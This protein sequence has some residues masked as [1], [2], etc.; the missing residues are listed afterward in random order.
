MS[1]RIPSSVLCTL[2]PRNV[3]ARCRSQGRQPHRQ[4]L[5]PVDRVVRFWHKHE[6]SANLKPLDKI[7]PVDAAFIRMAE[8]H[9]SAAVAVNALDGISV[10]VGPRLQ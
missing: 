8:P 7:H 6:L 10:G 5:V 2:P 9:D 3:G 4:G 1:L